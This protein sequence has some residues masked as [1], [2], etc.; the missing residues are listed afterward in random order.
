[1]PSQLATHTFVVLILAG[2]LPACPAAEPPAGGTS[3][4]SLQVNG[5]ASYNAAGNLI[6]LTFNNGQAASAF[7]PT[8]FIFSPGS[9][10]EAEIV[11]DAAA[12]FDTPPAD[13]LT[14]VAQNTPAGPSYLGE[15]GSGLGFFMSSEIKAVAATFDY[16]SNQI[17]GSSPNSV[18]IALSQGADLASAV[19]AFQLSG[20]NTSYRYAWITYTAGTKMMKVYV[21]E[22]AAKP[23]APTVSAR[24][25]RDLGTAFGGSVYFGVTAGTGSDYCF[26]TLEYF[27]VE[28]L[29]PGN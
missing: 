27:N 15:S 8:P 20:T 10:F 18:G 9:S 13:G 28:V 1:M 14:F 17:T 29:A 11:F 23:S 21:S 24:I 6:D 5:S 22:T 12:E 2:L 26:Q 3:L 7:I 19:P 25:S 4:S 16:A